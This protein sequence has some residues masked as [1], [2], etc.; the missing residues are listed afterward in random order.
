[1]AAMEGIFLLGSLYQFK[2]SA[3]WAPVVIPLLFQ[4][5]AVLLCCIVSRYLD[6][7]RERRNIREAFRHYLP[8]RMLDRMAKNVF[9][10]KRSHEVVYGVCLFAD[11]ARYTSI[12]EHM[13]PTEVALFINRYFEAVFQPIKAHGGTVSD[14]IGDSILAI[15]VASQPNQTPRFHACHAALEIAEVI[16]GM[17]LS[18]ESP[19][20]VRIGLHAGPISVGG[21]GAL[22]HYEFRAVGDVVNT[23]SR[24]E[25]LNKLLSTRILVAD[26]V[27]RNLD[28]F[29]TRYVG[30]FVL[31]G[32]SKP[33]RLHELICRADQCNDDQLT[34]CRS[35]NE[36]LR[37]YQSRRWNE[38]SH[39]FTK[40]VEEFSDGPAVF[41]LSLCKSCLALPPADD[42][43]GVVRLE[44]K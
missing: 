13:E 14:I 44:R 38:A 25:N 20:G 23:A 40:L 5:P 28:G 31:A 3:I 24:I 11:A 19:L 41:Y 22:E 21:I 8:G 15:W 6:A 10:L 2:S 18:L 39:L 37:A 27:I 12:S 42:W 30:R 32:K 26:E 17:V 29:L 9:D 33:V 1:M 34:L 35:F 43:D 36:G 16:K 7:F 4:G